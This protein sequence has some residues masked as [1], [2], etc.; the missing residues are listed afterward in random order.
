MIT[1]FRRHRGNVLSRAWLLTSLLIPTWSLGADIA[2][3][4]NSKDGR[5]LAGA[6]VTIT[7]RGGMIAES[8]Y[9][10]RS[11]HYS[12]QTREEGNATIRVRMP[13][14][15]DVAIDVKLAPSETRNFVLMPLTDPQAIADSVTASAHFAA[16][17]F[18]RSLDKE[19]FQVDCLSCHQIGNAFTRA[20]RTT[21]R[22]HQIVEQMLSE[23]GLKNDPR[24]AVYA[25]VLARTF[26]TTPTT[27]V[28]QQYEVYDEAL[29]ARIIEWKLP[30]SIYP[31]DTIYRV[32]D[33]KFY[34]VDQG[35]DAIYITDPV[36]GTTEVYTIP[37]S[38]APKRAKPLPS[39][40]SN[41]FITGVHSP[42]SVQEGGDGD[43]YITN[44][45]SNQIGVFDPKKRAYVGY[46]VGNNAEYP[47]TLRID[48][49]G[50]VW[51][52]IAASNQIGM[53]DSRS[54]EMRVI[55]LPSDT[56]RPQIAM[57]FPYGIDISPIDDSVWYSSLM[58]NRIGRID[59]RTY[60]VK[61]FK[62][63]T[64]GPR[65]LRFDK[66]GTL[67]IPDYGGGKL[68]KLDTRL[69][70]YTSYPIPTLS[71]GEVEAPYAVAVD[72]KTQEVWITPNMSD[73]VF[74]FLPKEERFI[75]YPLPARG[76][77]LRDLIVT[78]EGFVCGSNNPVPV[79]VLEGG[80]GEVLCIDPNAG[81]RS[82]SRAR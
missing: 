54:H 36:A 15:A 82:P 37:E 30:G 47:H 69:M 16:L 27:V 21:E 23:F 70:K 19:W 32:A 31:H 49:F 6:I 40:P 8:V 17:Q 53:F 46:N 39:T 56:D 7:T 73:R 2:G 42:H 52:T 25:N 71:K 55:N 33:R 11:G 80:M 29:P 35:N 12:L 9:V 20:P 57:W 76:S 79:A 81:S 66:D 68:V 14:F 48:R 65:R 75:A 18:P 51:F 62:P 22:W 67:W 63:P 43:F 24:Q 28:R 5:P 44:S 34:T 3:T 45:V 38:A 10:G 60:S 78:P 72:P 61:S 74:R 13:Y 26:N 4:V 41:L 58:A 1:Q 77:Y 50:R 64:V 59:P